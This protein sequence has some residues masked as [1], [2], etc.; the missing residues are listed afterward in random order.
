MPDSGLPPC[1]CIIPLVKLDYQLRKIIAYKEIFRTEK[2]MLK[3]PNTKPDISIILN[4]FNEIETGEG[5]K[6][7]FG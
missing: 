2:D 7:I 4:Q 3:N 5:E 1:I 6:M